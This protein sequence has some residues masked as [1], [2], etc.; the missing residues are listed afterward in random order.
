[1][2]SRGCQFCECL[3]RRARVEDRRFVDFLLAAGLRGKVGQ[4][5]WRRVL[6]SSGDQKLLY[7]LGVQRLSRG[8]SDLRIVAGR[9]RNEHFQQIVLRQRQHSTRCG[10]TR[11]L[12]SFAANDRLNDWVCGCDLGGQGEWK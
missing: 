3:V 10:E 8:G 7:T 4:N 11:R 6:S 1:M 5:V 2:R 9:E 12:R